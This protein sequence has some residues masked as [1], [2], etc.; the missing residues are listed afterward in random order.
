MVKDN[1]LYDLLGVQSNASVEEINKAYKKMAFKYH[2]D[3]NRDNLDEASKKL[4]EINQAKEILSNEEKRN[5]YD[6]LGMDYVN[7]AVPQQQQ[8]NPEDLFSMFGGFP[9]HPFMNV[10]RQQQ[11]QKENIIINKEVTLEEIYNE[12]HVP[13]NFEQKYYCFQCNGEGTKDGILNKCQTCDGNGVVIRRIQQGPIIQQIQT[14]CHNCNGSG[15]A[16]DV[17]DKCDA[18]NGNG[19]KLREVRTNIPLKNGL[20]HGQQ[21]QIP[22]QGHHL[23]DG[24]TDLFIIINE[25]PHPIFKCKG[26]D[27]FITLEL[28]LGQA[29]Y[30]FHKTIEHLDKRKLLLEFSE[31]TEYNT[32]KKIVGEGMYI[33]NGSGNK[34]DLYIKFIF[35]LPSINNTDISNKLQYLLKTLDNEETL[36]ETNIKNSKNNY[37]KTILINSDIKTF[38]KEYNKDEQQQQQ[39]QHHFFQQ[40]HPFFQHDEGPQAGCQQS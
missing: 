33:L 30:G 28:T 16:K 9:G 25:K 3:K 31:K 35:K 13:V 10:R 15:K 6:Q 36:N 11:Q 7:G 24:K 22:K 5:M 34:G 19:Y 1:S 23:K 8:I 2:P 21:I 20:S 4:Q 40:G 18:C 27:L 26:N 32:V 12:A 37:I 38:D 39:Q 17:V 14:G 29:I